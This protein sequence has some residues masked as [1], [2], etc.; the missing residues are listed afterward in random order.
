MKVI[1]TSPVPTKGT[2]ELIQSFIDLRSKIAFL[3]EG[4]GL[5]ST[6]ANNQLITIKIIEAVRTIA[7]TKPSVVTKK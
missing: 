4:N 3:M 6:G 2:V 7:V 5:K 1:V